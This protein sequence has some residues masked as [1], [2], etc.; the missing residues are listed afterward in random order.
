M[1]LMIKLNRLDIKFSF[2]FDIYIYWLAYIS[3]YILVCL[4]S[5]LPFCSYRLV[6]IYIVWELTWL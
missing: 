2:V 4:M 5:Y 3:N 1:I 6:I